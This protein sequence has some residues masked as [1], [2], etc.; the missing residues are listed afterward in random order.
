MPRA[1]R[2]CSRVVAEAAYCPFCSAPTSEYV[3]VPVQ[4]SEGHEVR[5][6]L[7]EFQ[8]R[9]NWIGLVA[10]IFGLIV[11]LGG[12]L[13]TGFLPRIGIAVLFV[14]IELLFVL[15]VWSL[16]LRCPR[17]EKDLLPLIRQNIRYCPFCAADLAVEVY[18]KR[19]EVTEF[20]KRISGQDGSE[21]KNTDIQLPPRKQMGNA[22]IQ[23]PP[24]KEE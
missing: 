20:L 22:D 1:C 2:T 21:I 10:I 18:P 6:L 14:A 5:T 11:F 13:A 24:G 19:Q 16:S 4:R 12:V 3:P 15:Y 9:N 23:L 8:R 7:T 17:C